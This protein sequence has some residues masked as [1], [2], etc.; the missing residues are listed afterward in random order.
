MKNTK[1]SLFI[2]VI[3]IVLTTNAVSQNSTSSGKTGEESKH[4]IPLFEAVLNC[5]IEK[6]KALIAA[7]ADVN[8]RGAD[9]ESALLLA[10][11][12][13]KCSVE[14]VDILLTAGANPNLKTTLSW[15]PLMWAVTSYRADIAKSL[16]AAGADV[17]TLN[18]NG[19]TAL[20]L[21]VQQRDVEEIVKLLLASG[22]N[23]KIKDKQN[24]TVIDYAKSGKIKRLLKEA[25]AKQSA[26]RII[27]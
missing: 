27:S 22:T 15:T 7:G 25:G 3:T 9:N 6:V 5:N 21:V 1:F 19:R 26:P 2:L 13:D 11:D 20:M 23:I 14:I 12:K 18:S 10:S 17:N 4:T 24:K 8:E 16:I